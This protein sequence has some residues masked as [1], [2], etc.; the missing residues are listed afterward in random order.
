MPYIP[1]D[2]REK[3]DSLINRLA[4]I[5]NGLND[6]DELSGEMNYV[7]FRLARLLCNKESSGKC[8]Y[9][10]MAVVRSALAEARDEFWRRAMIP[11]E[12][13]KTEMNGDVEL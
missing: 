12:M 3:Y 7:L 5:L 13:E 6:N 2:K 9:A 11:Y 4:C 8:S 1:K 10:R